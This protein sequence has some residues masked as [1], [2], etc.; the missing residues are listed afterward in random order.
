MLFLTNNIKS[1][2]DIGA[3]LVVQWFR[4]HL[5]MQGTWIRS[6]IL[7]LVEITVFGIH[8]AEKRVWLWTR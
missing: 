2:R 1:K 5:P 6:L 4:I 8:L 7:L 3:S